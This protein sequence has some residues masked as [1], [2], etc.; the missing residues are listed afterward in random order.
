MTPIRQQLLEQY[1]HHYARANATVD[2]LQVDPALFGAMEL[3]YGPLLSTVPP[4]GCVLDVG[5]GAGFLLRWLATRPA[6][7]PVGIDLSEGQ[8]AL[9][10]RNA[11]SASVHVGDALVYLRRRR[12]AFGAI[13]CTDV[14][15]HVPHADLLEWVRALREAL[16]PGGFVVCKVPNA[17]NLTGGQ[18]RYID[19]THE[20]SF[21]RLSLVQLLEAAELVDCRVLPVRAPHL[22]GRVRLL[23]ERLLHRAVYRI[24]GD[25]REDVFTRTLT[26]AA[27]RR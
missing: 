23:L 24:C 27:F 14:L 20:R 9:A 6:I 17:A 19:L 26:V 8:A 11:P 25:G 12:T 7:V 3:T 22:S 2:A 4:G 13:F 10:R 21:T 15:E 18:L 5:C 16:V 1:A